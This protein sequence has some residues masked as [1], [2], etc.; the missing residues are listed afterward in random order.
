MKKRKDILFF[1]LKIYNCSRTREFHQ[2]LQ[3][4]S[5]PDKKKK[6]LI[7]L[8]AMGCICFKPFRRSPS[9]SI[10]SSI[11]KKISKNPSQ[12]VTPLMRFKKTMIEKLTSSLS[13]FFFFYR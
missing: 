2:A 11:I 9:P 1:I 12:F 6:E 8:P 13:F 7:S 3:S 5:Q 10:K 4:F